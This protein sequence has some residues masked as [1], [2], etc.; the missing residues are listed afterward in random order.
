MWWWIGGGIFAAFI[1][2]FFLVVFGL[3]CV[4]KSQWLWFVLGFIFPLLWIVGATRPEKRHAQ[5]T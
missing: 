4:Q 2:I 5:P 3:G 1:W